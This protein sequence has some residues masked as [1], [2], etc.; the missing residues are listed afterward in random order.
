MACVEELNPSDCLRLLGRA[1]RGRVAYSE[2]AMPAIRTLGYAMAGTSL[3]I[4][5]GSD[6]LARL[7]NGQV[8]AFEV[9]EIDAA[10]GSG[11]S[12]VVTGAA[13]LLHDPDG[14]AA[15]LRLEPGRIRGH[16]I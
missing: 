14:A 4:S 13:R 3:V 11:W 8:V 5:T 1:S 7:L 16:R 6:R 15:Q 2:R 12:V 10:D 9:D